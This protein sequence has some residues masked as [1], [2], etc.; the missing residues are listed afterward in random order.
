VK[1]VWIS[2]GLFGEGSMDTIAVNCMWEG[3]LGDK[4]WMRWCRF[5]LKKSCSLERSPCGRD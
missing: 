3:F 2:I 1:E 4:N 5:F